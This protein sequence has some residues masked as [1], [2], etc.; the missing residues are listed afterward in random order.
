MNQQGFPCLVL[1]PVGMPSSLSKVSPDKDRD[2]SCNT[3]QPPSCSK[4]VQPAGA[5]VAPESAATAHQNQRRGG[6]GGNRCT[7][8]IAA[9]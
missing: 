4:A 8:F 9:L 2:A 7:R 5:V 3:N 1:A 6:F